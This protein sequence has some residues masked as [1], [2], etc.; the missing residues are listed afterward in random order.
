MT[1]TTEIEAL[2]ESIDEK[3]ESALSDASCPQLA[4]LVAESFKEPLFYPPIN[5]WMFAGD[6]IAILLQSDLPQPRRVLDA[7]LE[8]IRT[9]DVEPA[10]MTVVVSIDLSKQLDL[11]LVENENRAEDEPQRY[12]M[13]DDERFD[14]IQF[15]I[16]DNE[17]EQA[18]A[19]LAANE[20]GNPVYVN[21]TLYDA[22]VIV[23][24]SCRWP[25]NSKLDP[26]CLYP[27]FSTLE[28]QQRFRDGKSNAKSLN[29]EVEL[30]NDSLGLFFSLE[31]VCGPGS[32]IEI[33]IAG[34]RPDVK[35][36]SKAKI[37]SLWSIDRVPDAELVIMTIESESDS[38]TWDDVTQ[39]VLTASNLTDQNG[40]IVIWS[41]ISVK[42][43]ANIHK[44]CQ[45]QF[46][47][48]IDSSL[49]QELQ[50]LAGILGERRVYLRSEL[51]R[52]A[53]EDLGIGFIESTRELERIRQTCESS[54]LVRDGHR[55]RISS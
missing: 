23:P 52:R 26:N 25:K 50:L 32:G 14:A 44:A 34:M 33:V 38:Q 3:N 10:D 42:P 47:S 46:E 29:T 43:P 5:E 20:A 41:K 54:V 40:P 18:V 19:Y 36:A 24:I 13:A 49:P 9:T 28:C 7:V 35:K 22:D 15:E 4:Q 30:A 17:N 31:L 6:S 51:T 2:L 21:R 45:A 12:R 53:T 16:H 27:D 48:S 11:V 8:S 39:A 37:D 55:Q 1:T